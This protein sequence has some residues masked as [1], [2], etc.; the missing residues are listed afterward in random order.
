MAERR[1]QVG[2]VPGASDELGAPKV[3]FL[4]K[5]YQQTRIFMDDVSVDTPALKEPAGRRKELWKKVQA[6]VGG[7]H[8]ALRHR[9][10]VL[11]QV[12]LVIEERFQ[13]HKME[14]QAKQLKESARSGLDVAGLMAN[15]DPAMQ[16][17]LQS[18]IDD[19]LDFQ[20]L[21]M[22]SFVALVLDSVGCNAE[23]ND[24][25]Q[26]RM[27]DA[28]QEGLEQEVGDLFEL[29]DL[30]ARI[31]DKVH[32]L[33]DSMRKASKSKL[34]AARPR[35]LRAI[36]PTWPEHVAKLPSALESSE[37]SSADSAS[38][39]P[40]STEARRGEADRVAATCAALLR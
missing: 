31:V 30:G 11:N 19:A 3:R 10:A 26:D 34:E 29:E 25:L 24:R 1:L 18:I 15:L 21:D 8:A 38:S 9:N 35:S 17:P 37:I 22:P 12:R 4:R 27:R 39:D 33:R 7:T 2:I 13:R 28:V 40:N 36:P 32:A 23:A 20:V 14:K 5:T 6:V 16:E